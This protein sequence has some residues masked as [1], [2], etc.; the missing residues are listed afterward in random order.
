MNKMDSNHWIDELIHL[1]FKANL[2]YKSNIETQFPI[3]GRKKLGMLETDVLE[4]F[5]YY[6]ELSVKEINQLL[7]IPNSTLTSVLNRL[8]SQEFIERKISLED[9]RTYLVVPT[10]KGLDFIS[11]RHLEKRKLCQYLFDSIDTEIKP[12]KIQTIMDKMNTAIDN[13]NYDLLRRIHMDIIKKEYNE[14][15]P[16]VSMINDSTELP[17]QFEHESE[18]ILSANYA[19]KIPRPIERRNAKPGMPLYDHV[20]AFHEAQLILLDR[21][22]NNEIKKTFIR[23]SDIVMI[24][25]LQELLFG[26]LIITTQEASFS[27][28][29]NPVSHDIIEKFVTDIRKLYYDKPIRFD[30]DELDE[31]IKIHSPIFKTIL[32]SELTHEHVKLVEYQPF[33]ELVRQ[34]TTAFSFFSDLINKPVLQDSIFLT[35]GKELIILSRV[36]E[37]KSEKDADYGYRKTFIPLE[38]IKEFIRTPDETMENLYILDIKIFN[39]DFY[40]KISN[41]VNISHLSELIHSS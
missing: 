19:F 9:K 36:K 37:V 33:I 10:S 22:E 1:F 2:F 5:T 41:D 34:K 20:V 38:Y 35:N 25:S 13:V 32:L 4:L 14:F 18:L 11:L 27:I 3:S 23:L 31:H 29:Y 12:Q 24:Q 17:P 7:T 40:T 6:K 30:I 16:W 26:E 21:N 15:G 8:E 39:T 28:I